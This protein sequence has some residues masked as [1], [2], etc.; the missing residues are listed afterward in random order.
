MPR[1]LVPEP[2]L[3]GLAAPLPG[4]LCPGSNVDAGRPGVGRV[5]AVW[6]L[7]RAG[8]VRCDLLTEGQH[9]TWPSGRRG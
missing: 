3:C 5:A 8:R 9:G 2:W 6:R 1:G 4:A 7:C